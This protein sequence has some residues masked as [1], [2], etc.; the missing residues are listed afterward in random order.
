MPRRYVAAARY[1]QDRLAEAADRSSAD[2]T[3]ARSHDSDA[4][5]MSGL[6]AGERSKL[7]PGYATGTVHTGSVTERR[8]TGFVVSF[9]LFSG[10]LPFNKTGGANIK[11]GS[12]VRVTVTEFDGQRP[13]KLSR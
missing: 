7:L 12:R 13:P 11:V 10:I 6:S 8:A 2:Q 5:L 9:G 1:Q 4:D 3:S